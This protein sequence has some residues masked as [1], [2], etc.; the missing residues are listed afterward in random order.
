MKP[1]LLAFFLFMAVSF[2]G[3]TQ[4]YVRA[5]AGVGFATNTGIEKN[6]EKLNLI[7]CLGLEIGGK[8]TQNSNMNLDVVFQQKG[9]KTEDDSKN[10]SV[11]DFT[12]VETSILYQH[13]FYLSK[14]ISWNFKIG[15]YLGFW[16]GGRQTIVVNGEKY[17]SAL[18]YNSESYSVLDLGAIAA[19]GLEIKR[20]NLEFRYG[21]GVSDLDLSSDNKSFNR[22]LQVLFGYRFD[23]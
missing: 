21:F 22:S 2:D 17:K 20:I 15:P 11:I 1:Y 8:I 13:S 10:Y 9:F 18:D 6:A 16:Q 14:D 19:L 12:Y 23:L 3:F 7:Y 4:D 5:F